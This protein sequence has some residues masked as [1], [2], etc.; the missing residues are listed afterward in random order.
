MGNG[1]GGGCAGDCELAGAWVPIRHGE[2]TNRMPG[3]AHSARAKMPATKMTYNWDGKGKGWVGEVHVTVSLTRLNKGQYSATAKAMFWSGSDGNYT[4][5]SNG[6]LEARYPS[7]GIKEYWKR[8]GAPPARP[9]AAPVPA[10]AAPRQSAS[11]RRQRGIRIYFRR[12]DA[13]G[14]AWHWGIGIGSSSWSIYEVGGIPMCVLGPNGVIQGIPFPGQPAAKAGGTRE[15]QFRGYVNMTGKTTGKTDAELTAFTK[16]WA[17][18]HPLYNASGPNCQTFVEDMYI[19]LTG[20]NLGFAKFADLKSGPEA[21]AN[22]VWL[23][24]R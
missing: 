9:K 24:K 4:L 8:S 7:S 16:Q 19:H 11:A 6:T 13:M 5:L 21:S 2:W 1:Q 17:N 3:M 22:A 14:I 18:R 15:N 12:V 20:E 10:R 23:K